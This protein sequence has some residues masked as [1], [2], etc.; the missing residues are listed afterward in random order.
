MISWHFKS[1][2]LKFVMKKLLIT[3][4]LLTLSLSAF[5]STWK[6]YPYQVAGSDIVFPRDEGKHK[7][8][9]KFNLEWW[10][11][12]VHAKGVTTGENYS[13]LVSH[14]NNRIRFFT[15]S[16]SDQKTHQSD[17]Q[18]GSLSNSKDHLNLTHKINGKVDHFRSKKDTQGK[19]IPF[20]YEVKTHGKNMEIDFDLVSQKPPLLINGT[21]YG[22]I[23]SS[24]F[25]WYYSL[26]R[27]GVKGRIKYK[28]INEEIVGTG[29]I[30]HQWGPF[31]VSPVKIGRLFE[32]YE[33]FCL[34]LDNG[35]DVMIS[36]IFDRSNGLPRNGKYGGINISDKDG[37]IISTQ[38]YEF[39]RTKFWQDPSS[40]KRFSMG[41]ELTI[42]KHDINLKLI[43]KHKNQMVKM[44]LNGDFWEG[45][46][47]IKGSVAGKSVSGKG[48][49]EL[50]HDYQVPKVSF[51]SQK[52]TYSRDEKISTKWKIKN[53][54]AGNPLK[55]KLEI[56]GTSRS[57][58]ITEGLENGEYSFKLGDDFS[59]TKSLKLTLTA[60][61]VDGAISS[62]KQITL[63]V[64]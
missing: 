62:N 7:N 1:K 26:T 20:E 18:I 47:G 64:R 23:G 50:M 45:S 10:Y 5:A 27:L 42:P 36:V 63:Q 58:V 19:L 32:S 37:N 39:K 56:T 17:S 9:P 11:M 49:G 61:S 52:K 13:I 21:G 8:F 38:G 48:F 29:W 59:K 16:N 30:D 22:P 44:V 33:W 14:F 24:G 15:I 28:G 31:V 40:K 3:A 51:W 43:P 46:L 35:M 57:V 12:V 4:L 53:P 41:W 60:S 6:H 34:Q 25:T 54:D 2:K 55:Y